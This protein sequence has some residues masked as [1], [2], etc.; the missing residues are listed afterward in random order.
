MLPINPT[1]KE[2]PSKCEEYMTYIDN[3]RERVKTAYLRFFKGKLPE[4]CEGEIS[5]YDVLQNMDETVEKNID[6]HDMSKYDDE[7]FY[8]YRIKFNPTSLEKELI[9]ED[10]EFAGLVQ[11]EFAD[12]WKQHQQNNT[13]HPHYYFIWNNNL[14]MNMV[15]II[16]MLCDWAAMSKGDNDYNYLS[17]L[18]SDSSKTERDMLPDIVKK[19]IELISSK[20]YSNY[21]EYKERLKEALF[22]K[23]E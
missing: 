5:D 1:D 14:E 13:H 11:E 21:D 19:S 9:Q 22:G 6:K 12:A 3:H 4:I 2:Y 7:E 17:W 8:G 18:C 23:E 20:I 16:E 10:E 15:D